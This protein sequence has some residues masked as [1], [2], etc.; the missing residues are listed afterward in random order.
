MERKCKSVSIGAAEG[1]WQGKEYRIVKKLQAQGF[2]LQART[3]RGCRRADGW[4]SFSIFFWGNI[5]WATISPHPSCIWQALSS[6]LLPP[7]QHFSHLPWQ[8][9]L[10]AWV[11][12]G[13]AGLGLW[14]D[15]CWSEQV[16]SQL[17]MP[18]QI[19]WVSSVL[20]GRSAALCRVHPQDWQVGQVATL[21]SEITGYGMGGG[22]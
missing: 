1:M 4:G 15:Q 21:C 3:H 9:I 13:A 14:Q 16:W 20:P 17:R 8:F 19:Q 22:N 12:L 18:S 5:W 6:Q 10:Q 11:G 7:L 2:L